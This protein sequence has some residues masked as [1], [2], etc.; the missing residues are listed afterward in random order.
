VFCMRELI[1]WPFWRGVVS[2]GTSGFIIVIVLL[3]QPFYKFISNYLTILPWSLFGVIRLCAEIG[4]SFEDASNSIIPQIIFLVLGLILGIALSIFLYQVL[5]R[6]MKKKWYLTS[7]LRPLVDAQKEQMKENASQKFGVSFDLD[8]LTGQNQQQK[9]A[10]QSLVSSNKNQTGLP[11]VTYGH[12]GEPDNRRSPRLQNSPF[13]LIPSAQQQLSTTTP[14]TNSDSSASTQSGQTSAQDN[15]FVSS[16]NK[17]DTSNGQIYGT[18]QQHEMISSALNDISEQGMSKVK[19]KE[20]NITPPDS[21]QGQN[22]SPRQTIQIASQQGVGLNQLPPIQ[23]PQS[24]FKLQQQGGQL[25]SN[26][27]RLFVQVDIAGSQSVPNSNN[28]YQ[29]RNQQSVKTIQQQQQNIKVK[30]ENV[31]R[32]LPKMKNP[33]EVEPGLRYLQE[34]DLRTFEYLSYTDYVYNHALKRNKKDPFLQ[35]NYGNFLSSYRK[36][37]MK[38][39]SVYKLARA[40]QPSLVLRFVLYCK[41]KEG[42]GTGSDGSNQNGGSG[43]GS[44]LMSITFEAKLVQ[45]KEAHEASTQALK[46]LFENMTSPNINGEYIDMSIRKKASV[47]SS[48]HPMSHNM[49]L[50]M[51]LGFFFYEQSGKMAEKKI[52]SAFEYR[53]LAE[54]L[55]IR[56]S[57]NSIE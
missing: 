41:T 35:F 27:P 51:L 17:G 2:V 10:N 42:G 13:S 55:D 19:D 26:S 32:G 49:K 28:F 34:R 16:R 31:S 33:D 15:G 9:P 25:T 39:Q 24:N 47:N 50:Y 5:N 8:P 48:I 21:Q 4:Y 53:S 52:S 38:A 7:S 12:V 43:K 6:Q 36:N 54:L 40:C 23:S 18:D 37:W 30:S 3:K 44:E 29:A 22:R 57:Q 14:P 46:S 56:A 1:D 20:I 45:A 11:Q